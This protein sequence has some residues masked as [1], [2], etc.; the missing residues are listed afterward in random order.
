MDENFWQIWAG[1]YTGSNIFALGL[2]LMSYKKPQAARY[3]YAFLFLAAAIAN[4]KVAL[5]NPSDYSNYAVYAW[6]IYREFIQGPFTEIIRPMVLSIALGQ[7]ILGF[8]F[9]IRA[10]YPLAC[11]GAILF[12]MAI[13]P[14][15]LGAAFPFTLLASLGCFFIFKQKHLPES[16]ANQNYLGPYGSDHKVLT[17][18]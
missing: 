13:T 7:I 9:L 14:L 17:E 4:A 15:G 16:P 12:F 3:F 5:T 8:G 11:L 2:L 1:P 18:K 6:P 10:L